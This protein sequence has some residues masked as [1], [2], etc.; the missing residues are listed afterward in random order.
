MECLSDFVTLLRASAFRAGLFNRVIISRISAISLLIISSLITFGQDYEPIPT[1]VGADA[2]TFFNSYIIS[3]PYRW[4]ENIHREDTR[5]W[6]GMQ[7]KMSKRY[8][9]K[10]VI[11]SNSFH[12]IDTYA[13]TKY[14]H[15]RKEG[16]YYFKYAYYNNLGVPALFYQMNLNANPEIIVD[17]NAISQ[18]DKIMLTGYSVSKDSKL[19]AY[20]F[21]RNGSDWNE[22]K[23]VALKTGI[24]RKDHLEGLKFSHLAWRGDGFFYTTYLHEDP[25]GETRGQRIMYHRI[26]DLQEMDSLVFERNS[27]AT[28]HYEYLTTS[29]ERFFVLKE[30]NEKKTKFNVYY[31]DYTSEIPRIQPLITNLKDNIEILDSH[32]GKFIARTFKD[33]NN[34]SLVELDPSNPYQ[35]RAIGFQFSDALLLKAIPFK[36]RIVALYQVNQHPNLLVYD[37]S[38]TV[39]YSLEFPIP[40]SVEGFNGNFNDEELMYNY[41]S[42][43]YP[44][45]VYKFNIRTFEKE[46]TRKTDVTYDAQNIE[47]KEIEYLSKDSTRVPMTLVYEKGLKLDGKNPTLLEAYGGF[48]VIDSPSFDPGIVYFI[49]QGGVFAFAN[50]RGGGD[51]GP[52]WARAGRGDHKQTSFDD[53][54]SAAEYL[55]QNKYTCPGKLAATGASNGGLVVAAAAIQ[56]PDLFKA[57][58]PVVAPLDMIRFGKFTVGNLHTDEYGTVKDSTS[59]TRLLHYSPYHNIKEEI[60]YPAMLIVTSEND[61]RVPPLHSYKFVARLQG[62]SAQKNPI[63]LKTELD[64]GHS[65]A[66]TLHS[67]I[68]EKADIYGFIMNEIVK[69][70]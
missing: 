1:K 7:N 25:L 46:L 18:K 2:D 31:I 44:P 54:I 68:K 8:L 55:V 10:A 61:D 13:Y 29:D 59:F 28:Y 39:L 22:V 53:F 40:S 30:A 70:N 15:P 66:S 17:P 52:D 47:Y 23:V 67:S 11:R 63:L 16:A 51:K 42:Y 43:T 65:G 64:S 33:G 4:M 38:G 48:G 9:E 69:D 12:A 57:V 20:Q 24:N 37:Y 45:M 62:R 34:G 49:K 6:M 32:D 27:T 21:S 19:L 26:G 5:E 41:S 35:W 14:D 58:V 3:D 36:D 50:I 60:N 56:R